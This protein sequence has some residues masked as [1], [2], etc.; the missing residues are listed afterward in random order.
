MTAQDRPKHW[1]S[2]AI[3]MECMVVGQL[4][5]SSTS[6]QTTKEYYHHNTYINK[7]KHIK[8]PCHTGMS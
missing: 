7:I 6:N 3:S 2:H 1:K 5:F 8:V 4:S